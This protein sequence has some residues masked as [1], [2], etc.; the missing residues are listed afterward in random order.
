MSATDRR[1]LALLVA[2]VADKAVATQ[3]G[4]S[5]RTV[6]RHIQRMRELA[7]A[8]TRMRLAWQAARRG[9]L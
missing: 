5:R 8:A 3:L 1:L 6:R 9:R 4:L 7:G 2:G